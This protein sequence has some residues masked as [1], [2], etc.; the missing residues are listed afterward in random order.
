VKLATSVNRNPKSPSEAISDKLL[1]FLLRGGAQIP[2]EWARNAVN[3]P[4]SEVTQLLKACCNGDQTALEQLAPIVES[5]LPRLAR[6]YPLKEPAGY[7]LQPAD[8]VNEAY[9]RLIGWSK[10]AWQNRT[11]C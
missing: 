7:T 8:L 1:S 2:T 9:L 6:G 4:K 10:V 5:E 3:D 11:H